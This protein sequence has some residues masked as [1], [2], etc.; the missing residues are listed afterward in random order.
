M[1]ALEALAVSELAEIEQAAAAL[2]QPDSSLLL[3]TGDGEVIE[4][5]LEQSAWAP[6]RIRAG[7]SALP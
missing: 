4:P 7:Y 6:T 5:I 3:I 2:L 1:K